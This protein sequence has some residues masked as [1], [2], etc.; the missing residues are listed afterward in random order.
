M[1]NSCFVLKKKNGF[2]FNLK[3]ELVTSEEII[4][5]SIE[6]DG[7]QYPFTL[8][9]YLDKYRM[10]KPKLFLLSKKNNSLRKHWK[11]KI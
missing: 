11:M 3:F 6:I 10:S 9:R 1:Q 7:I 5:G 2:V 4:N 8:K